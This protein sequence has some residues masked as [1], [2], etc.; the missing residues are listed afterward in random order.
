MSN[1]LYRHKT[2]AIN[3][4]TYD[5]QEDK[6]TIYRCFHPDVTILSDDDKHPY[7]YGQVLDLFHVDVKNNGPNTILPMGT[8][9]TI[10]LAWVC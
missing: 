2:L 1:T 8:V 6:D 9:A 4:T 5:M 3:Y 7:L 10:P